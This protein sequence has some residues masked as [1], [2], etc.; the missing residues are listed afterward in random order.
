M[1]KSG[2]NKK[3]GRPSGRRSACADASLHAEIGRLARMS[4]EERITEALGM[5][6]RFE[7]LKPTSVKD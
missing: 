2:D 1:K 4:V 3:R 7:A 6:Q 5:G